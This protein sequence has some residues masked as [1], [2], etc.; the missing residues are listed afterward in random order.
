MWMSVK[1]GKIIVQCGFENKDIPKRIGGT[2]DKSRKV[3]SVLM[4]KHNYE[5]LVSKLPGISID[6]ASE[7]A[8][9]ECLEKESNLDE[10]KKKSLS[11]EEVTFKVS[12]VTKALYNY[13]KL[14]IMYTLSGYDSV[15]LADS[16]GLGK[17]VQAIGVA[18]E[19][20]QK[21]LIK[22]C[23]VITPAS[24]K[25]NWPLEVEKFTRE[26]YVVIDGSADKRVDQWLGKYVCEKK[27]NGKMFYRPVEEGE[28]VFFYIVNM[29]LVS[30]DLFGGRNFKLKEDDDEESIERKRKRAAKAK[31]R[32]D[33]LKSVL[34]KG[35][36][37]CVVDEVHA[38]KSH[39]SQRSRNIKQIPSKY[40]MGL[41]GT[42][43]DGRL[44][45]LH[46]VMQFV[47]P[48]LFES[49]SMFM[50]KH[51]LVDYWGKVKEYRHIGDIKK[52]IAP[53]FLRRMKEEVLK[54][55]P[56]KIYQNRIV[57]LSKEEMK[58]YKELAKCGHEITEDA[59]AMTAIIRCKQFCDLPSIL[60]IK[61]KKSSKF[62]A[63]KEILEEV[64]I[65]NGH[66]VL[67]FSQYTSVTEV[68]CEELK[69]MG[70]KF[71]YICGDTPKQ[72]RANMQEVFNTDNSIDAMI[73]TEAM[74]TGLNFTSANYVINYDDNWSPSLMDQREDRC[75]VEGQLVQTENGMMPI[76]N[77][78]I[79]DK[80]LTH[81]GNFKKVLD[82]SSRLHRT[83]TTGKL[84][85]EISVRRYHK[86]LIST[87]DH[88]IFIVRDG[89]EP[90][91]EEACNV[92]PRDLL[93]SPVLGGDR[94]K[95]ASVKFP[96][97]FS[98]GEKIQYC[99]NGKTGFTNGNYVPVK[100][101]I[102][103]CDEVLFIFG[104]Y[105]AE[106]FSSTIGDKGRFVSLSGHVKERPILENI[107]E[108]SK[109]Y[110][111][112]SGS[113][114]GPKKNAIELRLYSSELAE[115]FE[116][117]FGQNAYKKRIPQE[118]MET[119]DKELLWK[120]FQ[121]Y[122]EGD[123]YKRNKQV[124]W[125]T[126]SGCLAMQTILIAGMMGYN[127]TMRQVEKGK[128]KGHWI[129]GYTVDGKSCSDMINKSI[130]GFNVLPVVGVN[131]YIEKSKQC[132]V[133]DLTVED[134]HSF[135]VGRS[136]VHNCHR[137]GQK[138]VVNVINFI[139]KDTIEERIRGVLYNKSKISSEVLGDDTDVMVL[140][141][142]NSLEIAQI[143]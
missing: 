69:N 87:H 109:K 93:L 90:Y 37:M 7:K 32:S 77:I 62:E 50:D 125:V 71:M 59:Q 15:L 124:E 83:N 14:G 19:R 118:W 70:L 140:S 120:I 103:L 60:D 44:E 16:M 30:E 8:Y 27:P 91:W 49:K 73:G 135:V 41:S 24:L 21:G 80:V 34:N 138:N 114:Y 127:P 68:L 75:I 115:W 9:A 94:I 53:F 137:I 10:I 66:K 128:N 58:I 133:Y 113:I 116:S 4:N 129:G 122:I 18:C 84:T 98:Y 6:E 45:E 51:A 111:G 134:D 57:E 47:C 72:E 3:W 99:P 33:N 56:D 139:C 131:T 11:N 92:K 2:W 64:V 102:P 136:I 28:D 5:Y 86:P 130:D 38:L 67:I 88:K 101:D 123:G 89:S 96:E 23:L 26:N 85:T 107:L 112:V 54:E 13:Q 39:S 126:V 42:P 105:L 63:F 25:W 82:V 117:I 121:A 81:K 142:L 36:D 74:S 97:V 79:G 1:D 40:R 119:W 55:L 108:W 141:K 20:K 65:E 43:L 12:G 22:N 132:R 143:L 110:F 48:G 95:Y 78:S 100:R 46:S 35:F 52:R 61:T 76:E 104:W 17:S 106:G 31:A 29:E